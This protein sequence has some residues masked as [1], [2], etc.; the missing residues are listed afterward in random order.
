MKNVMPR[1]EPAYV[2]EQYKTDRNLA[3]RVR[4]HELYDENPV[5][6]PGWILDQIP[7]RGDERVLDAGCGSGV[8]VRPAKARCQ[9]YIAADLSSGMLRSLPQPYPPRLNLNVEQLPIRDAAFDVVFANHMLYHVPDRPRAAAQLRRVLKPGGYLLA[10]TNGGT[11]MAEFH[12][13][14]TQTMA[15]MELPLD[16]SLT[17]Y[18]LPFTLENGAE[19]LGQHFSHVRRV[20]LPGALV[21]TEPGPVVDYLGTVR[22]RW[23]AILGK[24]GKT[25]EDVEKVMHRLLN[26]HLA[27]HDV[28]RVSKLT[29][30]FICQP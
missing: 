27:S 13:L 23:H 10:A 29:G 17:P 6:F 11:S 7:W 30:V 28:F 18:A 2:R 3:I 15:A 5:D 4:T 19:L 21:F 1:D 8:Y 24:S 14:A 16:E 26:E 9:T 25:W 20:D 12:Q 22:E